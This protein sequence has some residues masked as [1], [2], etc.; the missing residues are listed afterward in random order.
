M[1]QEIWKDVPGYVGKYQV[2]NLGNI[3]SLDRIVVGGKWGSYIR[4]G[5]PISRFDDGSGYWY[6]NLSNGTCARKT[7]VHRLVLL[8]FVGEPEEGMQACHCDGSRSNASLSNL[9]WDTG[10]ANM[11]DKIA[12]GTTQ[13]GER[14]PQAVLS[15]QQ[16]Q[17][18]LSCKDS[19]IKMGARLG[20][21]SSTI[22]AVRL[23]QN[24]KHA[25]DQCIG[26]DRAEMD[27]RTAGYIADTH[28]KL[29]TKP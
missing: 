22:R 10:K 8:A 13:R 2:S 6:V 3:R 14:S 23:G 26:G 15:L 7:A 12:H 1:T 28:K 19:S 25:H 18:I 27:Q 11:A 21:A 16:V 9:R 29:G 17:E 5:T 4:K 20:V 24:W